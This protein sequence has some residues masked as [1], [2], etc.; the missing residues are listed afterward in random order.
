MIFIAV[1]T[2]DGQFDRLIR[3]I[4]EIAPF[5]K[6][7]IIAQIG[8]GT[9]KPKNIEFFAF[10][11]TLDDYY[12]QARLVIVQSATSLIEVSIK[13]QKPVITVPR[14]RKYGEHI[15]DHQVEFGEYFAKKTGISCF[16]DVKKITPELLKKY[17]LTPKIDLANI[18]ELRNNYRAFFKSIAPLGKDRIDYF[19]NLVDPQK[20]D[21]VLNIGI[22]NIPE[23]EMILEDKV[24]EC[25]TIDIDGPKLKKASRYLH[26]TKLIEGDITKDNI[27]KKNYYD[28]VVICEVLEHLK[29]DDKVLLGV[30]SLLKPGGKLIISVPNNHPLHYLHPVTYMQ[31]ERQYT[32]QSVRDLMKK[33]GFRI[34]HFNVVECW[35]LLAN[36]YVHLFY[37]YILGKS[38]NFLTFSRRAN[39]SYRQIN[40][41]G[42][43][44]AVRAVKI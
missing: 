32:N 37:K 16:T 24:K 20:T 43:D 5:I 44:I 23:I 26:K 39:R 2:H 41:S 35:T 34:E 18:E 14:Q 38:K 12:R 7:K 6:E 8:A 11:P 28:K 36:L 15:N 21:K 22:S 29:N 31:H 19:V 30:R 27:L 9:Y 1:G 10:A 4:D 17:A 42:L 25:W 33:T 13:Y 40:K 3:R